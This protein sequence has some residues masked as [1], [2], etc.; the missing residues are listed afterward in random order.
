[1]YFC[2]VS[3]RFERHIN[4]E[5][6][7]RIVSQL[8]DK[9]R[10]E[11]NSKDHSFAELKQERCLKSVKSRF[12]GDS[13]RNEEAI[14]SKRNRISPLNVFHFLL[15][16]RSSILQDFLS[17]RTENPYTD[18]CLKP[19]Y[20]S[21]LFTTATFFCPQGGRFREVQLYIVFDDNW[22]RVYKYTKINSFKHVTRWPCWWSIQ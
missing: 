13:V 7:S 16:R 9:T 1:M 14:N 10:L 2:E 4:W 15:Y 19:L 3:A 6:C 17:R 12:L 21:H 11:N 22:E 18:S 20:N 8:S 5:R